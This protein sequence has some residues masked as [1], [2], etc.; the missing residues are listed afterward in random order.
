MT[1]G[2]QLFALTGYTSAPHAEPVAHDTCN[3]VLQA[4]G[5]A[6]R[7][8]VHADILKARAPALG[9]GMAKKPCPAADIQEAC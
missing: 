3:C 4:E 5:D 1:F 8:Y 9:A 6:L 7:Y 2:L